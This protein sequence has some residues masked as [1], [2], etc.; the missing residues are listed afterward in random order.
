M[1]TLT[2]RDPVVRNRIPPLRL[3][4]ALNILLA[5]LAFLPRVSGNP[6]LLWSLLSAAAALLIFWFL[7]SRSSARADRKLYYEFLPKPVHYV[8]LTMHSS[9]YAY[10]GFYWR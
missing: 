4:L 5:S 6:S 10:W 8:Q 3:A 1:A 7:L 9:I 2:K